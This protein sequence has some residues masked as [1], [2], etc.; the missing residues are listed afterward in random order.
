MTL[1]IGLVGFAGSGKGTVG[2][3][4]ESRGFITDSFAKPLKDAASSIFGWDRALLEGDTEVSRSWREQPDEFWSSLINRSFTPREALQLLGTESCR[5]VFHEN[6]WV[7]SLLKRSVDK[8]V[9]ITD[10]RF[11]NEID[12]IIEEGGIIIRVKRGDEPVWYNT[13]FI[14]NTTDPDSHYILYDDGLLM[15]QLYPDIHV[16]EWNWIGSNINYVIENDGTKEDLVQ[17]VDEI[18]NFI[19]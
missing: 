1:I 3:I 15:E 5:N 14:E 8:N 19:L 11:T 4:L 18:L 16:S 12:A 10:V 13:A 6:I 7:A 9:V 2:E 17:K